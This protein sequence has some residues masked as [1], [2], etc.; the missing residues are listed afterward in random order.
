MFRILRAFIARFRRRLPPWSDPAE[1][2]YA[3]VRQP[4]RGGPRDRLAA[5]VAEPE[6][7]HLVTVVKA[8]TGS[9]YSCR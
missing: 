3:G 4:R 5:S 8:R 7:D 6:P 9:G 1:D 2:V